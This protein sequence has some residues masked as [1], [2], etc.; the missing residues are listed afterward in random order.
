MLYN[1]NSSLELMFNKY[2]LCLKST[3]ISLKLTIIFVVFIVIN[4]LVSFCEDWITNHH[5]FYLLT[6]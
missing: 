2:N 4:D 1:K 6:L 3:D 5:D